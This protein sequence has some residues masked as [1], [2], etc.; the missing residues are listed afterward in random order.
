MGCCRKVSHL[1]VILALATLV[2]GYPWLCLGFTK[3]TQGHTTQAEFYSLTVQVNFLGFVPVRDA[4]IVVSESS[5]GKTVWEYE[6]ELEVPYEFYRLSAEVTLQLPPG[7]YV[8][9]VQSLNSE[10]KDIVL[11]EN[12]TISFAQVASLKVLLLLGVATLAV[13]SFIGFVVTGSRYLKVL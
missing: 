7:S 10:V 6:K 13:L 2:G 3:V 9:T 1:V 12:Q 5:S 4:K 11:D 8:V